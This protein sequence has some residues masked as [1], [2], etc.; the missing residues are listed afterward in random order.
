MELVIL[1]SV[2]VRQRRLGKNK[3]QPRRKG[4]IFNEIKLLESDYDTGSWKLIGWIA[5]CL[6]KK[7]IQREGV[8]CTDLE[9]EILQSKICS[10]SALP[11]RESTLTK[12][13]VNI[14]TVIHPGI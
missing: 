4:C 14:N 8:A 7:G 12:V 1:L 13:D 3:V 6:K 5:I 2:N 9:K 11:R 10:Y